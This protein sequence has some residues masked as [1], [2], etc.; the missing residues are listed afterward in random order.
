M[1]GGGGKHEIV[2]RVLE[3]R[4]Q[5][6]LRVEIIREVIAA[7]LAAGTESAR[8]ATWLTG[9]RK[10]A[11]ESAGVSAALADAALDGL[12]LRPRVLE[13]QNRQPEGTLTLEQYL[14]RVVPASRVERGRV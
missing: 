11:V 13:L 10:E 3:A 6:V 12:E 4:E 7:Q 2:R 8:F 1:R 14:V 9:L 5:A